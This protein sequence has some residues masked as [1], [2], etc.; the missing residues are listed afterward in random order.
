[1]QGELI[2]MAQEL[3]L[4]VV[5]WSPLA[6]GRLSG[7]YTRE[8]AGKLTGGRAAMVVGRVNEKDHAIVE[9]L[10]RIAKELDTTVPRVA[11][12]WVRS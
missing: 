11:L 1:M 2:P 12:A 7:K 10:A 6:S 9:D 4:G 5:P 3:G 8:N